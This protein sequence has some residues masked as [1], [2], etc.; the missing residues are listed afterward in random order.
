M[1]LQCHKSIV[2]LSTF[3]EKMNCAIRCHATISSE[4]CSKYFMCNLVYISVSQC[5]FPLCSAFTQKTQ[6]K[7]I[8][9]T[10]YIF[11]PQPYNIWIK[12]SSQSIH[13]IVLHRCGA[14]H[15]VCRRI[16]G[17]HRE[18]GTNPQ[19]IFCLLQEP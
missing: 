11:M 4:R 6:V 19:N 15:M 8:V 10:I 18:Q 14:V 5:Y 1:R 12:G 17:W 7:Q 13:W 16:E 3:R 9:R 2:S